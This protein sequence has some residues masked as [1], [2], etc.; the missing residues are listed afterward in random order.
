MKMNWFKLLSF[1]P[2][3]FKQ[4]GTFQFDLKQLSLPF[5]IYFVWDTASMLF[6]WLSSKLISI[7][8]TQ[9]AARKKLPC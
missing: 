2:D 8:W 9:N 1:L 4:S 7:G 6:G 5:I 3:F